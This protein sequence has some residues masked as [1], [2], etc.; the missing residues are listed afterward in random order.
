MAEKLTIDDVRPTSN[1]ETTVEYEGKEATIVYDDELDI[2]E[3]GQIERKYTKPDGGLKSEEY[4][5]EILTKCI[6]DSSFDEPISV[7]LSEA[8]ASFAM[9]LYDELDI[10]LPE[11]REKNLNQN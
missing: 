5:V 9:H 11:D 3:Y 7:V 2:I 6:I 8:G 1:I 10:K 4:I